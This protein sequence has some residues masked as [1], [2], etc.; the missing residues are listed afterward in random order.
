ML[1]RSKKRTECATIQF[2]TWTIAGALLFLLTTVAP[3][4]SQTIGTPTFENRFFFNDSAAP[5]PAQASEP[6]PASNNNANA[7]AGAK[8][9]ADSDGAR[10]SRNILQNLIT[11]P[12]EAAPAPVE[13][14]PTPAEAASTSEAPSTPAA[15][16]KAQTADVAPA[17]KSVSRRIRPI[18]SGRAAWY[19]HPGRTASGE[20][21]DPDRMT[22]AHKTLPFGTRLRVV[23]LQNGRTVVVRIN[24]RIPAK[25]KTITIDLSRGSARAIGIKG[26]GRVALYKLDGSHNADG[27]G[28][29]L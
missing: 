26:V 15:V 10:P 4:A 8:V 17:A 21:F 2:H 7:P 1:Q 5:G 18:G 22:A 27:P 28:N 11:S 9:K 25:T 16:R 20:K 3:L 23:N 24:D 12:A 19:E 14:G 13:A 6:P 29:P